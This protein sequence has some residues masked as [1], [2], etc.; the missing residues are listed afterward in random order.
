MK[1]KKPPVQGQQEDCL[2]ASKSAPR[3]DA[4]APNPQT[5]DERNSAAAPHALRIGFFGGTFDPPHQ[6]H[7]ALAQMARKLLGL[8][9]VLVA[10]VASQ[11]L[12]LDQQA[13]AY[14]DRLAMTRLAIENEPGLELSTVDAPRPDHGPNFM[15]DTLTRLR[16]T[17]PAGAQIFVLC[18]A[19][20]FLSIRQ[21]HRP[22]DLLMDYPFV[23]G[24][25]PGFDLSRLALALPE[26]LSVA[27]ERNDQPDLLILGLR[28][29]L[30]EGLE[31]GLAHNSAQA[32][33][34]R[35]ANQNAGRRSRLYL[36]PD[37]SN[38][39]SATE[40]RAQLA[41]GLAPSAGAPDLPAVL[42]GQQPSLSPLLVPSVLDY[43]RTHHLYQ[44]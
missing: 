15:I 28:E 37:L 42:A 41:R 10:P 18:G 35:L 3:T 25:R 34:S 44:S 16:S 22:Q 32:E 20:A 43:I 6:G 39:I 17:Q 30:N 1:A 8:D 31:E 5:L 36:L 7:L 21:W 2:L 40:L 38:N 12:K 27:A 19:D 29:G 13:T 11:P 9:R 33:A 4:P 24:A 26:P 23:I 14:E